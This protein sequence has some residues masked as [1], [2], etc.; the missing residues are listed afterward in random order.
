MEKALARVTVSGGLD[1]Y[2]GGRRLCKEVWAKVEV[3]AAQEN[4]TVAAK[5]A[6]LLA[7]AAGRGVVSPGDV[8]SF[9][10]APAL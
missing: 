4:K 8:A 9:F 1:C 3:N 10:V 7:I 2:Y 5:A 6:W